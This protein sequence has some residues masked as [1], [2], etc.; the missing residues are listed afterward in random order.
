MK[1]SIYCV[2]REQFRPMMV[3]RFRIKTSGVFVLRL[4]LVHWLMVIMNINQAVYLNLLVKHIL[5]F[6]QIFSW[7]GR[8]GHAFFLDWQKLYSYNCIH[9]C[10]VSWTTRHCT[11]TYPL[12]H[13]ILTISKS[14]GLFAISNKTSTVSPLNLVIFLDILLSEYRPHSLPLRIQSVTTTRCGVTQY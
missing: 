7:W 12:N 13:L 5:S 4:I 14:V 3:L 2:W 1:H 10:L 6:F 9:T 11:L 8:Y